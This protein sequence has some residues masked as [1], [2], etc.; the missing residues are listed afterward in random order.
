MEIWLIL[1]QMNGLRNTE[2][3][4]ETLR[5][6]NDIFYNLES[7]FANYL[8]RLCHRF[9]ADQALTLINVDQ[10]QW[11]HMEQLSHNQLNA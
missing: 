11:W 3:L 4:F 2:P 1:F 8:M 6:K 10:V 7:N 9:I 5:L